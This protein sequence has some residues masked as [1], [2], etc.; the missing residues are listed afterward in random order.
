M[1]DF[2]DKWPEFAVAPNIP[3]FILR[4]MGFTMDGQPYYNPYGHGN[5][6][7]VPL[8]RF[9]V[10]KEGCTLVPSS[11]MAACGSLEQKSR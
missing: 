10:K 9:Y 5:T 2:G 7:R 11:L 1:R 6:R 8:A 3:G 4:R